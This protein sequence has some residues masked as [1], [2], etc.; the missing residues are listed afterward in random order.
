[1]SQAVKDK[2]R[3]VQQRYISLRAASGGATVDTEA[4][5]VRFPF[6]SEEPIDMGWG[7]EILKHNPESIRIGTRQ[8]NLPLLYNHNRDDLLGR[9]E[10]I[11]LVDARL[12]CTVRF[13]RDARGDWAM[14]QVADG[15]LINCSFMYM[16]Y[17]SVH[18]TGSDIHTCTDWEIYEISLVTIPADAGSDFKQNIFIVV[19]IF[20]KKKELKFLGRRLEL[21]LDSF[22]FFFRHFGNFTI[23]IEYQF[24]V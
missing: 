5:T 13:G 3:G 8:D 18:E 11:D 12:Y 7:I 10:K 19:R 22:H 1:M 24:F 14:Q 16:E 17:K 6:S 9:V 15:I 23:R 21:G 4:R 20:R 2:R